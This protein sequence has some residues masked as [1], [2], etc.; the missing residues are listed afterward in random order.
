VHPARAF[1][2]GYRTDW[3]VECAAVVVVAVSPPPRD[4]NVADELLG[5]VRL[6]LEALLAAAER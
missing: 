4:G 6:D 5:R 1:D 2:R 3:T